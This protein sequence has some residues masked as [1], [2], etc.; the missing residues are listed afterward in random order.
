VSVPSGGYSLW[1]E[2]PNQINAL[3]LQQL[4][5]Q[6]KIAFCPGHVFSTSG[7]FHHYIRINCGLLW[8]HKIEH[9]LEKLGDL[10]RLL[11]RPSEKKTMDVK[12]LAHIKNSLLV[13]G[14]PGK[15]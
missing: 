7:N 2:L 14:D 3:E 4:A 11:A 1:I 5:I 15:F 12:E 6:H 8:N 9:A 13:G 10:V